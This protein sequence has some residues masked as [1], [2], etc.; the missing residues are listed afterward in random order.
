LVAILGPTEFVNWESV[1]EQ[2]PGRT[3]RQCR[4]RWLNY[5]SPRVRVGQWTAEEDNLLR[6][7]VEK[8]GHAWTAISRAFAGRGESDVKN[9][10]YTH[11]RPVTAQ[12]KPRRKRRMRA[13]IEAKQNPMRLLGQSEQL[14]TDPPVTCVVEVSG[15]WGE[16]DPFTGE[17][18]GDRVWDEPN[19]ISR[20]V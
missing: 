4:E 2:I 15:G 10:W 17:E 7:M 9:R 13:V 19:Q 5:L 14:W 6:A 11:L 1:A 12:D 8:L 3:A 20:F 16:I 18:G